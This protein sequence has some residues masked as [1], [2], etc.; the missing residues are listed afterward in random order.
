MTQTALMTNDTARTES[1][2]AVLQ[3]LLEG[4]AEVVLD[5]PGEAYVSVPMPGVSGSI[6]GH[7]RHALDHVAA[8]VAAR[9][10]QPLTYDARTRGTDVER[11]PTAAVEVIASLRRVLAGRSPASI[12]Q[13]VVVT[14]KI[15]AAGD[16]I[17][18]LS[19][20]ARELAFVVSHTVHHEAL[21]AML[22]AAQGLP[23]PQWFG[24]SP[25]TP[26]VES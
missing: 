6:G 22:L 16:T 21:I 11:D 25:S 2:Y 4:L 14:S 19:T 17:S 20:L 26:R 24:Y 23:A 3:Q 8:F 1:P 5:M 12:A 18:G 13:P 10:G 9:P 15:A 7:V